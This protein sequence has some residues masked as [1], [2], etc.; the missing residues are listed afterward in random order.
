[1]ANS[2]VIAFA[3]AFT[4]LLT[5]GAAVYAAD[6]GR[7]EMVHFRVGVPA[8]NIT[9]PTVIRGTGAP[10][11]VAPITIDLL[12]RGSLKKVLNPDIEG[13]STHTITNLGKK[14]V[15]IRMD[16]VNATI[17]IRWEVSANLPYDP[18]TRTFTEPLP[19]GKSIANLGIDWF[20]Q[21][22]EDRRYDPVIYD[23]GLKLSDADTGEMLTFLPIRVINGGGMTTASG[24]DCH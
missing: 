8:G 22:P 3:A 21:I 2:A 24:G 12:Q 17:P 18:E 10:I 19:P 11:D 7:T 16:L 9:E 20:F 4:F 1:M 6:F 5:L 14:P 23:G 13:L 15:K